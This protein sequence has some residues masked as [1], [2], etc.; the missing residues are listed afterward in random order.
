MDHFFHAPLSE[1]NMTGKGTAVQVL[2]WQG[3]GFWFVPVRVND[4]I[5]TL[6][7]FANTGKRSGLGSGAVSNF[8]RANT[9]FLNVILGR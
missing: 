4:I 8:F 6:N 1:E 2:A 3:L 9:D 5:I 7:S